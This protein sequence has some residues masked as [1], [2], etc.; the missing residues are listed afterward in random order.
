[1]KDFETSPV[2]TCLLGSSL[3]WKPSLPSP[4]QIHLSGR[5]AHPQMMVKPLL[6]AVSHVVTWGK[7][8]ESPRLAIDIATPSIWMYCSRRMNMFSFKK[9]ST[10]LKLSLSLIPWHVPGDMPVLTQTLER[11]LF[12]HVIRE[13]CRVCGGRGQDKQTHKDSKTF[14]WRRRWK[15]GRRMGRQYIKQSTQMHCFVEMFC[16]CCWWAELAC[17]PRPTW[18][19]VEEPQKLLYRINLR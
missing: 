9:K 14:H 17:S 11:P 18:C 19:E 16:C 5:S 1:M 7:G 4:R 2:N 10:F 3:I 12:V 15:T 6:G 13:I 8:A